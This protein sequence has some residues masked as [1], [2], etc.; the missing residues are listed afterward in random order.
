MGDGGERPPK[1]RLSPGRGFDPV[2]QMGRYLRWF[3][4]GV[5]VVS[6]PEDRDTEPEVHYLVEPF[7]N[8]SLHPAQ[9]SVA[10]LRSGP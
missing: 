2:D 10:L 3:K 4:T 7:K 8:V 1:G 6:V 5:P 9:T